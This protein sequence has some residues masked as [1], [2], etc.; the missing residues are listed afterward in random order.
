MGSPVPP[1]IADLGMENFEE[2]ALDSVPISLLMWRRHVDNA[3]MVLHTYF[4]DEF[5]YM[6]HI[7]FTIEQEED[8][9][10]SFLWTPLSSSKTT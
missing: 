4:I 2:W 5:T 7:Q 3:F 9:E 8:G 10:L 6:L 1:V